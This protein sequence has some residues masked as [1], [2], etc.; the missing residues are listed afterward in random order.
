MGRGGTRVHR[1]ND[2]SH[3]QWYSGRE[4][5]R[6][7]GVNRGSNPHSQRKSDFADDTSIRV[8]ANRAFMS[9]GVRRDMC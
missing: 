7:G 9:C 8:A 1:V 2:A 6:G 3:L 4:G 5:S